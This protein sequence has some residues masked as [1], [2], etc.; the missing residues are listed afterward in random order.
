LGL[1][2]SWIGLICIVQDDVGDWA[3]ESSRMSHIYANVA[4]KMAASAADEPTEGF[5][6]VR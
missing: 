5:L 6:G 2:F 1:G 4:P 3:E